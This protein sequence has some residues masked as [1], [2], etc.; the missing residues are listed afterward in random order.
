MDGAYQNLKAIE[1]WLSVEEKGPCINEGN[2]REGGGLDKL[3]IADEGKRLRY[4][5]L[6]A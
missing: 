4:K 6:I 2:R 3:N 1:R 5:D